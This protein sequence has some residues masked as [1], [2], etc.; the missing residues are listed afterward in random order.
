MQEIA[1]LEAEALRARTPS[2]QDRR[3]ACGPGPCR[4]CARQ[5]TPGPLFCRLTRADV[6]E[7][8]LTRLPLVPRRHAHP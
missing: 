4:H 8:R 1:E 3:H 2:R 6:F 7:P 5:E